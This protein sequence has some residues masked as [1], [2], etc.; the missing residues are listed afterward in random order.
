MPSTMPYDAYPMLYAQSVAGASCSADV[1]YSTGYSPVSFCGT[2]QTVPA[3]GIVRWGWHEETKGTGGE[4]TVT[5]RFHTARM[6]AK[7][8][9]T[10]TH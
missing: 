7:A 3:G 1:E 8:A 10:V 2:A 4:A 9:F 5:C 6:I